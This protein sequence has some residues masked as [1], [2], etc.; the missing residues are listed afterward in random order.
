MGVKAG[1]DGRVEG[2]GRSGAN[3][4]SGGFAGLRGSAAGR[5]VGGKGDF[6]VRGGGEGGVGGVGGTRTAARLKI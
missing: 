4:R 2:S 5:A 6:I 1:R 3:A